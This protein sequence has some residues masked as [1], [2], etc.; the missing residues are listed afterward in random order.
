[1][2]HTMQDQD[3]VISGINVTPLVDVTLV[4]LIIF[5]VTASVI[6]RSN[7]PVELPEAATAEQTTSGLL[8]IGVTRDGELFINGRAGTLGQLP[9]AVKE[10]RARAAED[11]QKNVSAF[12][13]ADVKA[14]YGLFAQVVDRLRLEGVTDIALDTKPGA[15]RPAEAAR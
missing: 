2:A 13:S 7:I 8:N 10:A 1:M 6:L 11:G 3:E 9:R 4:V 15:L 5:I 12:V 14:Q